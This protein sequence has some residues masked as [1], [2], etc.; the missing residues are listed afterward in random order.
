MGIKNYSEELG[1]LLDKGLEGIRKD[2]KD[3]QQKFSKE[4]F[5]S[6]KRGLEYRIQDENRK[7]RNKIS[8]V[9]VVLSIVWLVFTGIV[10]VLIGA[11][12]LE[13]P[14]AGQVS[15]ILGSLAEVFA[16]WK[17]SLQYFYKN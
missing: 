9:L 11:G 4:E 12:C 16:L 15:F 13:F 7:I 8:W 1:S 2:P 3:Y 5:D 17:I 10:F 14:V 6:Y